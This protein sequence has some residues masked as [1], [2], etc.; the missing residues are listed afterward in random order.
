MT[1]NGTTNGVNGHSTSH[2]TSLHT[3]ETTSDHVVPLL[4]NGEEI[5]TETTFDVTSP[6]TNKVIWRAS[7]VSKQDAIR[8]V[9]AA[10]AA[11]PAWSKTTPSYRRDILLKASDILARRTDE[12]AEY[13]EVETGSAKSYSSG[14]NV[15]AAVEQLR[16]VAG[17]IAASTGYTAVSSQEG[18]SAL[19]VKEPYGVV[20]GIAP[21]NAPYILGFRAISYALAAGNTCVLKGPEMSP[22]CYW[23]I[24]TVLKEAGLPDGCL[25]VLFHQP[26]DAA[27]ITRTIIEHPFVKKINYTGSSHIGSIVAGIAGKALKPILMELGGKAP[28]IVLKD[29]NLEKAAHACAIGAFVHS[30][31]ICMSTERI[32]VHTSIASNFST[33]LKKAVDEIFGANSPAPILVNAP[34]VK[35]NKKLVEQALSKGAKIISGDVN[36]TEQS[37]TRMRPIVVEGVTKEM[38]M[39]YTE[40]FGPT[41]SIIAVD[42]EDEAVQIANDTEY[43]LSSAVF[44]EDLATGLR[45]ARQIETGAVHINNMS[46]HD[47]PSLPH[48]GAKASGFGRFNASAGLEE[49]QRMKTLTWAD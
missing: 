14:L 3:N 32:L 33:A 42:S 12:A 34:P 27:E 35:K 43:G 31:Q 41:V 13:M 38:D 26:S 21:W 6:D 29:A 47:E 17:R 48:G 46:V 22:R 20:F 30:G 36:A 23:L 10:Q 15:P 37:E 25:N 16:D 5:T 45:V 39:Y 4:I 1:T 9:E 18:R 8:A 7:T 40:S 11:F 49:F 44:T 2:H 28:A 24:G 19:V